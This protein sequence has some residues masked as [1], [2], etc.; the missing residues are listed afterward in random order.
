MLWVMIQLL[1]NQFNEFRQIRGFTID[2]LTGKLSAGPNCN[3]ER[4]MTW[5]NIKMAV[6]IRLTSKMTASI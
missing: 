2:G 3:V 4:D 1:I 5:F 6:S